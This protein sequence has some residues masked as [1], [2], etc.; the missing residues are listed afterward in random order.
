[1]VLRALAIYFFLLVIFRM[2]GSRTLAQTT[3]FDLVLLLIIAESVQ[4]ALLGDDF[5]VTNA[6][7]LIVVLVGADI[8][9][10]LLKEYVPMFARLTEG[11]AVLLVEHGAPIRDRMDRARVDEEDVLAAAR[12]T[13]G[14]RRMEEIEYAVLERDGAISIIPRR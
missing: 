8:A 13:Q 12:Q 11:E 10:S 4:Q 9:L 6:L 5:S 2:S 3:P 7:V 1:M 14:L